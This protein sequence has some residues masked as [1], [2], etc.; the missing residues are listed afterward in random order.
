MRACSRLLRNWILIS[1]HAAGC[2]CHATDAVLLRSARV[3]VFQFLWLPFFC[4]A[5]FYDFGLLR[6]HLFVD[7]HE[8]MS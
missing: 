1:E 7:E 6:K 4:I 8:L 5:R 2:N 3:S